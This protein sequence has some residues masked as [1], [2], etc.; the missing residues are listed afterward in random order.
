[1]CA[2]SVL[3]DL[4]LGNLEVSDDSW[5]TAAVLRRCRHIV[6]SATRTQLCL[7]CCPQC[8]IRQLQELR[9]IEQELPPQPPQLPPPEV[10][11]SGAASNLMRLR[12]VE[13]PG[14][15]LALVRTG[16]GCGLEVACNLWSDAA[17]GALLLQTPDGLHG[18]SCT[19]SAQT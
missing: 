10:S 1:M 16:A 12:S 8:Y 11:P 3:S 9:R 2:S 6:M 4:S 19:Q 18:I 14:S 15:P 17:E 7:R 13:Q 5:E